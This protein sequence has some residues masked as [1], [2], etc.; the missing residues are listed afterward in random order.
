VSSC[1]SSFLRDRVDDVTGE[2]EMNWSCET[3]EDEI[4]VGVEEVSDPE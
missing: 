4:V 3:I 2:E 1:G